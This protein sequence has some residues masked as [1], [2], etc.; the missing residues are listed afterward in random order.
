MLDDVLVKTDFWRDV[1]GI[2]GN[3]DDEIT[4]GDDF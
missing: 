4:F 3:P 2:L 1:V